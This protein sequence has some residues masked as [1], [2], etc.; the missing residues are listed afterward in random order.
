MSSTSPAGCTGTRKAD[1]VLFL[2][3][4]GC[5]TAETLLPDGGSRVA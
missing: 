3:S 2:L 5:I 1:A 4:A